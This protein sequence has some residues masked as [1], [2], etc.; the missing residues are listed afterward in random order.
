MIP[1]L[2]VQEKSTNTATGFNWM[3]V[4]TSRLEDD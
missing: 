2:A 4:I 1:V 3:E